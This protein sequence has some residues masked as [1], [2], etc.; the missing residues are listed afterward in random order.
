M[1]EKFAVLLANLESYD[2]MA[3]AKTL[4]AIRGVPLQDAVAPARAAGGLLLEN[5]DEKA[6]R[7][8]AAQFDRAGFPSVVVPQEKVL[9]LPPAQGVSNLTFLPD[10]IEIVLEASRKVTVSRDRIHLIL[11]GAFKQTTFETVAVKEGPSK[12]Q[13]MASLGILMTTGLPIHIGG[14][15]K[16]TEKTIENSDFV[17]Y[18]DL[19]LEG[20]FERTR[21]DGRK[22]SYSCLKEK[23]G[24]SVIGNFP[25]LVRELIKVAP[26]ARLNRGANV[27]ARNGPMREAI[28][29]SLEE[30]DR[31]S[32]WL[33]AL[34]K[35]WK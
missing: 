28:Y 9:P 32:R 2:P 20:P 18:V 21:V 31:E 16:K 30:M 8:L 34:V 33:L 1:T 4:A 35:G 26:G 14:K 3:I 7:D 5:A 11:A 15:E 17:F 10:G 27:I 13:K 22:I 25:V 12:G 6:A 19:I 24:Y 23:M 29:G